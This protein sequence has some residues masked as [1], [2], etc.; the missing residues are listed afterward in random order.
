[1][2]YAYT[3]IYNYFRYYDLIKNT[4]LFVFR[5]IHLSITLNSKSINL[6]TKSYFIM[7]IEYFSQKNI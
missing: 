5:S 4:N 2:K 3:Q 1:M 7:D 6:L